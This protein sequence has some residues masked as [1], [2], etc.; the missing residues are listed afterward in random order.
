M[1]LMR[2]MN[3]AQADRIE[4]LLRDMD[5]STI[6][7][8]GTSLFHILTAASIAGS[9]ALFLSGRKMEG[10]FVGLWPPTFQALKAASERR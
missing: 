9:L 4:A 8:T 2:R 5:E 6:E 10:L 1:A 3:L 7:L